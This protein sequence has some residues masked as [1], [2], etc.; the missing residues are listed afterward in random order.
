MR[1]G[2]WGMEVPQRGPGLSPGGGLGA[3]TT[4]IMRHSQLTTSEN[5]NTKTYTTR[6]KQDKLSARN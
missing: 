2:V 6:Q 1:N 3:K 4:D 5:F